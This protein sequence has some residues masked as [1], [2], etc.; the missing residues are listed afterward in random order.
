[1]YWRP[2]IGLLNLWAPMARRQIAATLDGENVAR[3]PAGASLWALIR[4]HYDALL[5]HYGTHT[6]V[7]IARILGWTAVVTAWAT[8]G[9]ESVCRSAPVRPWL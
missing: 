9:G 4:E 8:V 6:G 2:P 3:A 7:R 1:M 5:G